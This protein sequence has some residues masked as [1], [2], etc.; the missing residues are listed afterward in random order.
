MSKRRVEDVDDAEQPPTKR[1][2]VTDPEVVQGP[3]AIPTYFGPDGRKLQSFAIPLER[4]YP[5]TTTKKAKAA[6]RKRKSN[7]LTDREMKMIRKQ[8]AADRK[9][10][11]GQ[12]AQES[13]R[14][15]KEN[16]TADEQAEA[17][18]RK[19]AGLPPVEAPAGQR[20]LRDFA[21]N[22]PRGRAR[23]AREVI[24]ISDEEETSD[25]DD[26]E[27][28]EIDDVDLAAYLHSQGYLDGND[29]E[30]DNDGDEEA[31]DLPSSRPP[32]LFTGVRMIHRRVV[33]TEGGSQVEYEITE[34]NEAS[35]HLPDSSPY[36]QTM[37]TR[38][39][40]EVQSASQAEPPAPSPDPRENTS[41]VGAA[42]RPGESS[43][44]GLARNPPAGTADADLERVFDA[45]DSQVAR[46][47]DAPTQPP[48]ATPAAPPVTQ[49]RNV[50][51]TSSA[52]QTV[53]T[54]DEPIDDELE[55]FMK[56]YSTPRK[57]QARD[58]STVGTSP[59]PHRPPP[60]GVSGADVQ[61][62]DPGIVISE[63][64][65][66][67]GSQLQREMIDEGFWHPLPA[68]RPQD[69]T[70]AG[71][72][73]GASASGRLLSAE[74]RREEGRD[75]PGLAPSNDP[76]PVRYPSLPPGFT[77]TQVARD[78]ASSG[79]S[80]HEVAH[81]PP[82]DP[83]TDDPSRARAPEQPLP[84]PTTALSP[85][86]RPPVLSTGNQASEEPL[87][88]YNLTPE[89]WAR[90]RAL[91]GTADPATTGK[92]EWDLSPEEWEEM[93]QLYDF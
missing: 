35:D 73:P 38:I 61:P 14:R 28:E 91:S 52:T 32:G 71:R 55:S 3:K 56:G 75:Q 74:Q 84:G 53:W 51:Y 49:D 90:V 43:P 16:R 64:D 4:I 42:A 69:T 13:R 47:I 62:R 22:Q 45:S 7:P 77:E 58:Q 46:E 6:Y 34:G 27:E 54:F 2:E 59:T 93:R 15:N 87:A 12:R 85:T 60:A 9:A 36:F 19:A 92:G 66:A 40:E 33:Q 18:R 1:R 21:T 23:S 63:E 65:L 79:E 26:E 31:P 37:R 76:R 20:L 89:E 5:K 81:N 25:E 68:S 10:D 70:E 50:T 39:A 80:S 41:P 48:A 82:R 29:E 44:T 11:R 88:D 72:R 57:T 8:A 78:F 17:Q 30:D 86:R 67:S 83:G 24:E